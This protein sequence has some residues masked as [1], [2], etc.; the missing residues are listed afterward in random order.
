MYLGGLVPLNC[1]PAYV[2]GFGYI[3]IIQ[4][5]TEHLSQDYLPRQVSLR[6]VAL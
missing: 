6:F 3:F 1:A 4:D 2:P 5:T